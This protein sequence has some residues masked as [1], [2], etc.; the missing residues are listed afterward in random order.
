MYQS[1]SSSFTDKDANTIGIFLEQNFPKGQFTPKQV[2]DAARP[3]NSPIH[4]Y[5]EWNNSRAAE[6]YRISQARKMVT[7][8]VAVIDSIPEAPFYV[9]VKIQKNRTYIR[10]DQ[11]NKIPD[12][13]SQVL[14]TALEELLAWKRRY[15]KFKQLSPVIRAINK[16][17]RTINTTNSSVTKN[18]RSKKWQKQKRTLKKKNK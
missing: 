6:L 9:N 18:K 10:T 14:K 16:I 5:F 11:A 1:K 3:K 13:W 17:H 12:I 4:K 15:E 8:V 7:C 2:V